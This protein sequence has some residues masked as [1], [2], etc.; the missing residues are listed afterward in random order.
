MRQGRGEQPSACIIDSQSVK[1]TSVGGVRGYDGA[2]KICGRK[3]HLLVDVTGL[4]LQAT[5]HA[6][7]LQDRAGVPSVLDGIEVEFPNLERIWAGS[8]LHGWRQELD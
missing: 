8:R 4:V 5:V 6:A 2:K 7:D 1:T 3:R